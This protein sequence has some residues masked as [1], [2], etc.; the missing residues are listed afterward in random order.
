[1]VFGVRVVAFSGLMRE[2]ARRGGGAGG[3]CSRLAARARRRRGDRARPPGGARR[4]GR[5]AGLRPARCCAS[6]R[7]S[8]SSAS[9]PG[10]GGAAMREWARARAGARGLRRG[11]RAALRRLPRR[12]ASDRAPRSRPARPGGARRA[13]P[14]ARALGRDARV[15][16]RLRRPH[17]GRSATRSRRWR[18]TRAP[19]VTVALSYEPGRAAFAGRGATFQE[20]VALGPEHVELPARAE[21]YARPALH[22]PRAHA[23][24]AARGPAARPRR[25]AAAAR[26]RRRARRARAGR[27]PRRPAD[28]RAGLRARGDRGRRAR[29]ARARGAARRRSSARC[30]RAVRAGAHDRRRAHRARAAGSSPCCAARCSTAAPTT[31]S[32]GCARPGMLARPGARRSPRGAR[33]ARRAPR[34]RPRRAGCGRP[35]TPDFVL[36]ELDRVAD[37]RR[38]RPG[39]AVPSGWPP[40]AARCSPRRTAAARAVLAGP[41]ALDAR[42]AGGAA[43][44]RCGE[45]GRAGRPSTATLRRRPPS[46]R[47]VLDDLEVRAHDE[48]APGARAGHEPARTARP[49]RARALPLRPAARTP[50]RAPAA[51][52][53][54]LGDDER[55]ALNAASGLR[56]R[57]REDR[58]RRRALS[59]STRR[60][61]R[62]TELLALSW[63]AADDEGEPCVRSLFVDDVVDRFAAAAAGR[64]QRR[65]LGAA[66][67][68]RRRSRRPRTR[69]PRARRRRGRAAPEPRRW[70][71][72]ATRALLGFVNARATRGRPRPWRPTPPAR[73]SGSSTG[74]CDPTALEPDPEPMLRGELAHRVLEDTLRALSAGGPLTPERLDEAR[75]LLRARARRARRR[76]H[77]SRPTP[78]AGARRCAGWRPTC[79]ATS[80]TRPTRQLGLRADGSSSCASAAPEDALARRRAGRR[81]AA[82]AGPHRPHRRQRRTAREAIVY[83]YKGKGAPPQAKWLEDAQLQVGL[84][85]LALPPAARPGGGR[86]PLPAA[87]PRRRRAPARPA[88]RRRRSR[89]WPASRR[90]RAGARGVR[91]APARRCWTPRCRRCAGSASGALVPDPTSLRLRR[92]LRVPHDLPLR[93]GVAVSVASPPS[94]PARSPAARATLML[95]ANAGSGKTSVLVERFVRSVRRRRPATR[96]RCWPSRSP[97]RRRASC[98]RACAARLLE[99]GEREAARETEGAW[100]TT[101][102]GFCAR[103]LRAHAVAAGPGPRLRGPRSRPT[104][105]RR[106]AR[107]SSAALADFLAA[108]RADA[109]DLAAAYTVDRLQR[110]VVARPRRAARARADAPGAAGAA[111]G[112]SRRR[113]RAAL[114]PRVRG[115]RRRARGRRRRARP[116]TPRARR[117]RPAA[118]AGRRPRPRRQRP[119]RWRATRGALK[120]PRSATRIDAACEATPTRSPSGAPSRRSRSSTSCCG[121][122][123]DAYAA[124]KARARPASTSTTSSCSRATCCADE[125]AH[126]RRLSRAL[127]AGHGRRVPGHQPAPARAARRSWPRQRVHGRATSCSR[128]TA[129]ATPTSRSSAARRAALGERGATATLATNFRSRP[130]ILRRS[131]PPSARAR[132]LGRHCVPGATTRGRRPSRSWSC[133]SPT[134]TG[135]T[136]TRPTPR[137]RA[138]RRRAPVAGRGAARG[139]A[140]RRARPRAEPPRRRRRRAPARRRP[141]CGLFERALQRAGLPTLAAAGAGG[142][143]RQV[144]AGPAARGSR[145]SP[146][147]A[148]SPRSRRAGLA[149]R[150]GVD[151]RAGAR[152]GDRS[153]PAGARGAGDRR[154]LPHEEGTG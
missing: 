107:P 78:S 81:R 4:V 27:R 14:G 59:C 25:C 20:L 120:T 152:G 58:A 96:R 100:I 43:L 10:A 5:H 55:R 15:P 26:G 109:L 83:D 19:T 121:R 44:A 154:G 131:T 8:R 35:S 116:S 122:Y 93:G 47:G 2:I 11:A 143:A 42:V 30:E 32:P 85:L 61:R 21:H 139:P 94:R 54:F 65:P 73:S 82:P 1:M 13:A 77:A 90:D 98:A 113:P 52:E 91:R 63:P 79:C 125:P 151:R 68:S 57:L 33:A 140:R 119:R 138:A 50:S 150:R 29:A 112:R 17:R 148:T 145:R 118:R 69:R 9:S 71:R 39:R 51:P 86:R 124:A 62:P 37:A 48:P 28:R 132:R 126:R 127:R 70:P 41:E 135:G 142:G 53:P 128:S 147:R 97:R 60:S 74:C 134:P 40:S 72:C 111:P 137:R 12:P 45:L 64:V 123:A 76:R 6:C 84:Y 67:W 133:W 31:C 75:A 129:S 3:R 114:Q 117:S 106:C 36:D 146:T 87:G 153:G 136:A 89:A 115:V 95:S 7:S 130:E 103:V 92:R 104:A 99:L 110:M 23:V 56:L 18:S 108:P 38:A 49:A 24:R 105:A 46:S 16:L 144:S 80:S 149:A 66:G 22:A 101:F 88:A 34:P 141:T 102:H